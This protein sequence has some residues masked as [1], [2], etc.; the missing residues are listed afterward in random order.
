MEQSRNLSG[1]LIKK[2]WANVMN[3][4]TV[5]SMRCF[6]MY[7]Y[8]GRTKV[9]MEIARD[10][11][12]DGRVNYRIIIGEKRARVIGIFQVYNESFWILNARSVND[13]NN[14]CASSVCELYPPLVRKGIVFHNAE[15]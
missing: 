15:L 13:A 6:K 12:S 10:A 9:S 11:K 3:T 5:F 1:T 7:R 14:E 2:C 8:D 4:D